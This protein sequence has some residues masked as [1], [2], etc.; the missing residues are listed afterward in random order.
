MTKL[1]QFLKGAAISQATFAKQVGISPG[2]ASEIVAGVKT[3]GLALAIR[4][5]ALPAAKYPQQ[6][7][8]L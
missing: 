5:E 6:V 1:S 2:Y 4:I 3:P 8:T 7:G